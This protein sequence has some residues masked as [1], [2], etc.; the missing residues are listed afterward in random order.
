MSSQF[1]FYWKL[2]EIDASLAYGLL[3]H[4]A[5]NQFNSVAP[6]DTLWICGSRTQT[7]LL[8]IGPLLVHE[9][10]TQEEA[11]RRMG[12]S[13]LETKYHAFASDENTSPTREVSLPSM[14]SRVRFVSRERA[15]LDLGKNLGGQLQRI[16]QLT[17]ESAALISEQ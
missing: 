10:V 2:D 7:D 13:T 11:D 16:R 17:P 5:S 12:G 1:M 9:M 15:S 4:A 6:G 14:M 3:P 8:T